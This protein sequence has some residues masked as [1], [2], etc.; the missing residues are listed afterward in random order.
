[1]D[2]YPTVSFCFGFKP[3]VDSKDAMVFFNIKNWKQYQSLDAM[4]ATFRSQTYD[5]KEVLT[6]ITY[7]K[8]GNFD[9]P[10]N[11]KVGQTK[12][13]NNKSLVEI[14]EFYS[15]LGRCYSI[16]TSDIVAVEEAVVLS[17]KFKRLII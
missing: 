13:N 6:N 4:N 15:E 9:S 5:L 17:L 11:Y 3:E 10:L 8:D 14:T 7:G 16:Y 1:M 12:H 2:I